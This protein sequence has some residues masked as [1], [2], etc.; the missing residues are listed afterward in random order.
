[1]SPTQAHSGA[2]ES[3]S[4]FFHGCRRAK[5]QVSLCPF[6]LEAAFLLSCFSVLLAIPFQCLT[7]SGMLCR[8]SKKDSRSAGRSA[9]RTELS[10]FLKEFLESYGMAMLSMGSNLFFGSLGSVALLS[11]VSSK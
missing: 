9:F 1:M 7:H 10:R 2:M 6:P 8:R 5:N 3:G 11:M 4:P